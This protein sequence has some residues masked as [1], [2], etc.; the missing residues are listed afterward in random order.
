MKYFRVRIIF[1][2]GRI[3]ITKIKLSEMECEHNPEL[4]PELCYNEAIAA[5]KALS[6]I[7]YKDYGKELYMIPLCP[8]YFY[9]IGGVSAIQAKEITEEDYKDSYKT[10]RIATNE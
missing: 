5:S 9:P 4:M 3:H 1:N 10:I 2:D 7:T 6:S 8:G